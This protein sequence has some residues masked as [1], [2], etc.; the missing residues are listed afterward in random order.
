M[1]R[2]NCVSMVARE[3]LAEELLLGLFV[4]VI[5]LGSRT[6]GGGFFVRRNGLDRLAESLVTTRF[7][8]IT[9]LNSLNT[10]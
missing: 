1:A 2:S 6:P 9:V 7:G 10:M 8:V 4:D 5:Y 3:Q